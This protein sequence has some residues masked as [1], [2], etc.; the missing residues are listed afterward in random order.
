[1]ISADRQL[2]EAGELLLMESPSHALF[3]SSDAGTVRRPRLRWCARE[4][5]PGE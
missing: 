3:G 5:S 1:V 2:P 4:R